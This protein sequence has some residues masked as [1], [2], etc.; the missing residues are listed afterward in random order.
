MTTLYVGAVAGGCRNNPCL[1][2]FVVRAGLDAS[3]VFG[4]AREP[5]GLLDDPVF[6]GEE[7][8]GDG[9]GEHL[10]DRGS[11][12]PRPG[13]NSIDNDEREA[14]MRARVLHRYPRGHVGR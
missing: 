11:G 5:E 2:A 7:R 12:L 14:D 10:V 13:A 1:E 3:R 4:S 8:T 6:L 9:V